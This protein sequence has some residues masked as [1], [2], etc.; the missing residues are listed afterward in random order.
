M[1]KTAKQEATMAP[2]QSPTSPLRKKFSHMKLASSSSSRWKFPTSTRT[3]LESS[4]QLIAINCSVTNFIL[5]LDRVTRFPRLDLKLCRR[6]EAVLVKARRS[7][8]ENFSFEE[9]IVCTSSSVGQ[10]QLFCE[11]C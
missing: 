11:R 10:E 8:L 7:P 9:A 2:Q 6:G 3:S 1:S 5:M 4:A